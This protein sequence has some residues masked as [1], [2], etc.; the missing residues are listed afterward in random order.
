MRPCPAQP[1]SSVRG[2]AVNADSLGWADEG[3]C[4][5]HQ[6]GTGPWKSIDVLDIAAAECIDWFNHR[7]LH[8]EIDTV[9]PVEVEDHHYRHNPAPT[10]VESW[11][12]PLNPARDNFRSG[13]RAPEQLDAARSD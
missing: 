2:Q 10:T 1:I 4:P 11:E 6:R 7:R 8:G 9:P 13:V 3:S 12:P 5:G